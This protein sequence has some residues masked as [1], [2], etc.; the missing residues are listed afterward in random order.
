MKKK[1]SIKKYGH[2][3]NEERLEIEILLNKKYKLAEI[4]RALKRDKSTICRE[5]K[6]NRRKIRSRG[7]TKNGSYEARVAK[8]KSYLRRKNAKYQGKKINQNKRLRNYIEAG[9][10]KDW[11]PDVIS[12]RM[13]QK[14]LSFYASKTAIYE[15]LYC[16]WG[17]CLCKYLPSKRY[18]PKKR[19][20]NKTKKSLIPLRIGLNE[21]PEAVNKRLEYGHFE[22]DTIVS[23][24]RHQSKYVLS[25]MY[26][27]KAK[28]VD[29]RRIKSLKPEE[30]NQ[31]IKKMAKKLN[32]LN[33][34]TFDNGVENIKHLDLQETLKIK[35]Y[36]CN[37]Y[38]SWQKGGVENSNKLIRRFIPKG[39]DIKNYS[40]QYIA[41][42]IKRL[43]HTP[44]KS[45]NYFTP[46]EV[47]VK[48]NLLKINLNK[49]TPRV[50][51][52]G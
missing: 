37:P 1:K 17:Q 36:F 51:L 44:R 22:E 48:N 20:K 10:K 9:L 38:S 11:S 27:R 25:V 41:C 32:F 28:Y 46:Y 39:S 35:T 45:L 34:M 50:A 4:A 19:K 30:H 26:E 3:I 7:G 33:S 13:N 49:N 29:A 42:K 31:A 5:I 8:H 16:P 15:Y 21:R 52:R 14:G 23:G 40:P 12:G 43:N 18:K 47:M 2:L 6:R 24:K